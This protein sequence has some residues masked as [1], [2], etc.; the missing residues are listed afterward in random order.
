[1]TS[2]TYEFNTPA[3]YTLNNTRIESGMGQLDLVT[4]PGLTFTNNID[5]DAGFAY[6]AGLAEFSA[7]TV[8]AVDKT[9]TDSILGNT[10]TSGAAAK[11]ASWGVIADLTGALRG[12][13]TFSSDEMACTGDQGVRYSDALIGALP[14]GSVEFKYTP[15][16][17]TSPPAN[18]NM[19]SLHGTGTP[20]R[21]TL[22][23]SPSGDTLR[24]WAY[25]S[26]GSAVVNVSP[27]GPAFTPTAGQT[28]HFRFDWDENNGSNS[29]FNVYIDDVLHGT[30][31]AASF[32][33]GTAAVNCD[34][35]SSASVYQRAEASFEDLVLYDVIVA[36]KAAD[37]LTETRCQ[38]SEIV[39]P[40][41]IY[42]GIGAI[43]SLDD[44]AISE[45]G[46]PRYT[47]EGQYW[48]GSAWA[49]SNGTYLQAN[50][51]AT[52]AAN[53]P[54]LDV[55]GESAISWSAVFPDTN[56]L[57]SLDVF[58]LDY[59]GESLPQN[60]TIETNSAFITNSITAFSATSTI[61]AG[62][63]LKFYAIV[64]LDTPMYWDGSA[65]V[66]SNKTEAQTNDEA[67][68]N[69][70]INTLVSDNVEVQ[71][72]VFLDRGALEVSPTIDQA[73]FTHG[74]GALQPAPPLKCHVFMYVIDLECNP[75]EGVSVTMK[76]TRGRV[77]Y[78]EAADYVVLG[79]ITKQTDNE[80]FVAFNLIRSSEYEDMNNSLQYVVSFTKNGVV[81]D[82]RLFD[83][84][85]TN[86]VNITEQINS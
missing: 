53:L 74:F 77:P 55:Y 52:L 81:S 76:L 44:A 66:V 35:G 22:T 43:A 59:T 5:D 58:S 37:P 1:M 12:S 16:Y 82:E 4:N 9:P 26:A 63:V 54:S 80:G 36:S 85:D 70:N 73:V 51:S 17:T 60:G 47:V 84:P 79:E 75:L 62:T 6:D 28:Y 50:D 42:G 49:A 15:N 30:I 33:R 64:G 67:T 65:W 38:E 72:G 56:T 69:A 34:L 68:F 19:F 3:N 8:R 14:R 32:T 86:S 7:G 31:T 46:N 39:G 41:F 57:P 40:D 11:D 29:V 20:G 27:I 83:V 78:A 24:V 21:L 23:H 10:F 61:P 45:A 48:N 71:L 18:V 25:N 2:T 13:P